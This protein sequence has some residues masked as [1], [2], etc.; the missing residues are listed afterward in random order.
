MST[1]AVLSQITAAEVA[2]TPTIL[3]AVQAAEALG[4]DAS[5]AEKAANVVQAVTQ[6]LGQDANPN[7]A[8]IATQVNL[9]VALANLF[10][11]FKHKAQ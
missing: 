5:G 10:G 11:V 2:Y 9:I 7:V 8:A 1:T 3:T 4:P 6:S